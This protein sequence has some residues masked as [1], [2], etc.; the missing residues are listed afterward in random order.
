[1]VAG[2]GVEKRVHPVAHASEASGAIDSPVI[3]HISKGGRFFGETPASP[4]LYSSVLCLGGLHV[5]RPCHAYIIKIIKYNYCN[6]CCTWEACRGVCN[7]IQN[8]TY[9]LLRVTIG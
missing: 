8:P 9:F 3:S 4:P 5:S 7:S 2:A 6:Y 1:M